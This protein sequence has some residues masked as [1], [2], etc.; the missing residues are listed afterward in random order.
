MSHCAVEE[1]HKAT[2]HLPFMWGALWCLYSGRLNLCYYC[3]IPIDHL[4]RLC[5][6]WAVRN[7]RHRNRRPAPCGTVDK[8]IWNNHRVHA[9]GFSRSDLCTLGVERPEGCDRGTHKHQRGGHVVVLHSMELIQPHLLR[10][11]LTVERR[12]LLRHA[13]QTRKTSHVPVCCLRND[14]NMKIVW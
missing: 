14:K 2:T 3:G 13:A 4:W 8:H 7:L 6:C 9:K 1:A 10:L 12:K 11:D 5:F